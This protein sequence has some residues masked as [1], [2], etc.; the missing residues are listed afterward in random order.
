MY[1]VGPG[2]ALAQCS[3]PI[4]EVDVGSTEVQKA[5]VRR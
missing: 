2:E 1:L 4:E 3:E 5:L